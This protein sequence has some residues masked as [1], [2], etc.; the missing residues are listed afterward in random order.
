MALIS[1]FL[2]P[3]AAMRGSGRRVVVCVNGSRSIVV[4]AAG[5][6]MKQAEVYYS[7]SIAQDDK[8]PKL[9]MRKKT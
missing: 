2:L 7:G 1:I 5:N 3:I 9:S 4:L 6:E 8:H